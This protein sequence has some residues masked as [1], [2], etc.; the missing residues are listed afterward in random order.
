LAGEE[1]KW[2]AFRQ[3][4]AG[5]GPD[6]YK[7]AYSKSFNVAVDSITDEQRQ[8]GKVEELALGYGGGVGAFQTMAKTYGVKMP[9]E[10]AD[11]IKFLWREAHPAIKAYWYVL[12]SAAIDA[13][14]SNGNVYRAGA[15]GREVKYRK[16]GSF[17]WCQ[18]PSGRVL[19]YPYPKIVAVETPW[20]EMKDALTYM[21]V[22][23]ED[24]RKKGKIVPDPVNRR[25]WAR[26]STYGGMLSENVTQ[27]A[28]RDILAEA[29]LR[30]DE[31]GYP[32]IMHVHDEIVAEVPEW[33]GDLTLDGMFGIM[34]QSPAWA[35]GLP[36]AVG[37]WEG[38]RYRK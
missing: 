33:E 37:G 27:A 12:E 11:N 29:M 7:L 5:N 6:I 19:C 36:I 21:V 8:V 24:Q 34:K 25:D 10:Q 17:L 14:L 4:D 15:A 23:T 38:K 26:I 9:D 35:T 28:S 30:V 3:F 31:A 20:G 22:P 16:R 18:L 32:I 1:W 2:Y 13:V